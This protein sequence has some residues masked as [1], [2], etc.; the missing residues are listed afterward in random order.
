MGFFRELLGKKNVT[1]K[2]LKVELL[3][4][5]RHRKRKYQEIRKLENK[6]NLLVENIK[7]S[8]KNGNHLEVDYLWEELQQLKMDTSY[9]QRE[10]KV[11]NL[12]G[13]ALKRYCRGLERLEKNNDRERVGKLL[14]RVRSSDLDTK[15]AQQEINEKEYLD[16]LNLTMEEI[17]LEI[18]ATEAEEDDPA[19]ANFL[20][21]IDEINSAEEQGHYD[22]AFEKENLLK[23]TL[24]EDLEE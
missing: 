24:E 19:K 7:Q 20:K 22:K 5:E 18:E 15:L 17:G 14:E 1:S 21:E 12:E 9:L 6:K 8:R 4:L 11:L 13:I 2:D 10:M 3:K 23:S 16:E